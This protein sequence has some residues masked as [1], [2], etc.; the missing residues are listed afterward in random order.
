MAAHTFAV[1]PATKWHYYQQ[2]ENLGQRTYKANNPEFGAYINVSVADKPDNAVKVSIADGNG[3]L[4]RTIKDTT[5]TAGINRIVWNLRAEEP[6][7]LNSGGGG[8][9]RGAFRP[10]VDHG[11]YTATINVDGQ[12]FVQE[13]IVKPDPRLEVSEEAYEMKSKQSAE[14]TEVLSQTNEMINDIDALKEQLTSL[15][16][17]LKS[18]DS[19]KYK[20]E[21]E[22]IVD[23]YKSLDDQRN[24][25]M[26]PPG[27]MNY[28]TR[29]RL[30]EEILSILFAVDN[31]PAMPTT[32]QM[33][34]VVTLK[35]EAA[36]KGKLLEETKEGPLKRINEAVASLPILDLRVKSIRP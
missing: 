27:S 24:E 3:Q 18:E 26:R 30:R 36:E 21:I 35:E 33:E 17:R 10:T 15:K 22:M 11:T 12:E 6:A 9:W 16:K 13:I 34:R 32:P 28:R 4:V 5:F 7:K 2:I 25:L 20:T 23:A 31:T 19:E 14:L 8:G 29:P 1:R